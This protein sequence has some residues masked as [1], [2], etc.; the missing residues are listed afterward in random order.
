MHAPFVFVVRP[1][2]LEIGYELECEGIIRDP[3]RFQR[4]IECVIAA[5]QIGQ[6]L[7]AEVRILDPEGK[8]VETLQ[9]AGIKPA[10]PLAA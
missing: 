7:H 9:V 1:L 4:L 10:Q 8:V 2:S 6:G 5:V 3:L